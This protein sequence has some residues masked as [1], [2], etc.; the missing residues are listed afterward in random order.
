MFCFGNNNCYIQAERGWSNLPFGLVEV[1][2][3][4]L[5]ITSILIFL[6]VNHYLGNTLKNFGSILVSRQQVGLVTK[7]AVLQNTQ[8]RDI[9]CKGGARPCIQVTPGEWATPEEVGNNF[10]CTWLCIAPHRMYSTC[11]STPFSWAK[12][13]L[14]AE[15]PQ[16]CFRL[17]GV[18]SQSGG[19]SISGIPL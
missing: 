4:A 19:N 13:S 1:I 17:S 18:A 3:E 5:Q 2:T 12:E 10:V 14:K 8:G 16:G 7:R 11:T 6:K 15:V 9:T